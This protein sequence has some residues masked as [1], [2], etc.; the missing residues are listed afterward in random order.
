MDHFLSSFLDAKYDSVYQIV[1]LH[2]NFEKFEIEAAKRITFVC[3][4]VCARARAHTY[5]Q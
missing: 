1:L 2:H 3:V 5:I 4:F